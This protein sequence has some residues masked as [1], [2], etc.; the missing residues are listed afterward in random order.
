[1]EEHFE[2][3]QPRGPQYELTHLYDEGPPDIQDICFFS[4]SD[5][6]CLLE[7][8]QKKPGRKVGKIRVFSPQ[9]QAFWFVVSR[10]VI[11]GMLLTDFQARVHRAFV[12]SCHDESSSGWFGT[13]V[14]GTY[15][16]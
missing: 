14:G 1:M 6:I 4:G 12:T 3:L 13:P 9:T 7:Q 11:S 16:E 15:P 8:L 10:L 5:G 2:A